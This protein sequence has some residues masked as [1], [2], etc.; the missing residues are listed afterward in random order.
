MPRKCALAGRASIATVAAGAV[1][2]LILLAPAVRAE[3][4]AERVYRQ[5]HPA[6]VSLR[7][8]EAAGTGLLIDVEGLILTNAH[9][10]TSPLPFRA[11]LDGRKQGKRSRA[12]DSSDLTQPGRP[13]SDESRR[14]AVGT[15]EPHQLPELLLGF[16]NHL[17]N[18]GLG[19]AV[20]GLSLL[21]DDRDAA[22]LE[23][24]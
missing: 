2:F 4:V 13:G 23:L 7:N 16:W 18:S 14:L 15:R 5:V 3:E 17:P 22:V 20:A 8:A 1:V 12:H 10:I 11:R 19:I 6:V 9:V 24:E 21:V